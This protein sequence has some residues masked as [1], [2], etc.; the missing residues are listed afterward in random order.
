MSSKYRLKKRIFV[1]LN[2]ETASE[3]LR[4][5]SDI[6]LGGSSPKFEEDHPA[7]KLYFYK[8]KKHYS[9]EDMSIMNLT[10]DPSECFLYKIQMYTGEFCQSCALSAAL[11]FKSKVN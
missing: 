9:K 3:L 6:V 11:Y 2:D 10:Y 7:W 4:I 8:H 5:S 1:D